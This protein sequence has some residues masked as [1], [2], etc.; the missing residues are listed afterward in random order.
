MRLFR[1]SQRREK[2]FTLLEILV[3]SAIAAIALGV[4]IVK[5]DFSDSQRLNRA[6]E[7]LSGRLEAARDE[8]VIRGQ[9]VAFS[10]DGQGYQFWV[11]NTDRNVWEAL[12]NT[13]VISSGRFEQGI[14]LNALRVNGMPRPLGERLV[15]SFNGLM[16]AFTLTLS[17][18]TATLEIAGDALGR[19]EIRRA[20]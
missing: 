17:A 16:E 12:P 3:A 13:D 19:I 6:A 5:L 8:A 18:G 4:A 10:T 15:F 7:V 11:A 1:K 14:T 9:T 2:G 20:L